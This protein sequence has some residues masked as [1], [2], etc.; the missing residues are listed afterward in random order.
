MV[1]TALQRF[2]LQAKCVA[3]ESSQV[4]WLLE[5]VWQTHQGLD[6]GLLCFVSLCSCA[7]VD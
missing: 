6:L 2:P 1:S 3:Q 7:S 5:S 4:A